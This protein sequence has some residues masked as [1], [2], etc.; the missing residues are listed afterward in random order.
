M[1]KAARQAYDHLKDM[2]RDWYEFVDIAECPDKYPHD[3]PGGELAGRIYYSRSILDSAG[4]V[5]RWDCDHGGYAVE[6]E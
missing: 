5:V 3:S 6:K 2:E 1:P 4:Y